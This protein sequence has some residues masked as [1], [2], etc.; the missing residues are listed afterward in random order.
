MN[1]NTSK[2]LNPPGIFVVY[3]E[4][5][6]RFWSRYPN[7]RSSGRIY[8]SWGRQFAVLEKKVEKILRTVKLAMVWG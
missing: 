1:R 8:R 2:I 7:L 4:G 5:S 3:G 6:F